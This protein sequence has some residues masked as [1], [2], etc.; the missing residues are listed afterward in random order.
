MQA[1]TTGDIAKHCGVNFR[2]VIRW[3]DKGHLK[4]YKLPGRGNNRILIQ[5]FLHFLQQH[6]MPIPE[7]FRYY[8]QRVLVV[9]DVLQ[10]ADS[11]RRTLRSAGFDVKSV[12]DGFQA[13]AVLA[14]FLPAVMTLDLQMPG[15][16]GFDVLDFVRKDEKLG[17]VKI[18]V[19]SAASKADLQRALEAGADDLLE[20]PFEFGELIRKVKMLSGQ[21]IEDC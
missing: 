16:D 4:A 17:R 12:T 8:T 20:K 11:I 7:E 3:I 9:D 15:L 21:P 5:D 14:T 18:L 2:T 1:L 6:E 19:V 10:M 13:G